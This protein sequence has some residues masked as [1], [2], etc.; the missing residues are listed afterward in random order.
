MKSIN[1]FMKVVLLSAW[2]VSPL[3]AQ[4]AITS[5]CVISPA[6]PTEL[7]GSIPPQEG[8]ELYVYATVG[9]GTDYTLTCD[10]TEQPAS[11]VVLPGK[12]SELS[13]DEGAGT[14]VVK[15]KHVPYVTG[16]NVQ[17]PP[18]T[19]VFSVA[20]V[21]AVAEGVQGP[22]EQM[23]GS[24]MAT[25]I[26]PGDWELIPPSEEDQNPNFGYKLSGL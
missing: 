25:N 21:P 11:V 23:R 4:A 14:I 6:G 13:Y 8:V 16:S 24:W 9:T 26:A 19:E 10:A 5:N 20:F 1:R 7:S 18:G 22:P 12:V 15:F 17:A 3:V 2:I